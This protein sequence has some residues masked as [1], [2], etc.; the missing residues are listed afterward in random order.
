MILPIL[1]SYHKVL[2]Y[3]D[4]ADESTTFTDQA[5]KTFT[6]RG[7]AQLD[8]AQRRFGTASL[9]LDGTGDYEDTPDNADFTISGDM[10]ILAHV[11]FS[12]VTTNM[13][14]CGQATDGNNGWRLLFRNDLSTIGI[15]IYSGGST[16]VNISGSWSPS[17]N[18]WYKITMTRIGNDWSIWVNETLPA[19]GTD[20]SGFG[21]YTGVFQTGSDGFGAPSNPLFGWIDN[22]EFLNGL[23][24]SASQ[25]RRQYAFETGRLM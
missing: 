17:T 10:S 4:G 12:A 20:T 6:A 7:N 2:Q 5:G 19:S 16:I 24:Y 21:D 25:I 8:T 18:T 13:G 23:G 1:S 22:F 3:F 15:Q 9:L 11:R 14:I